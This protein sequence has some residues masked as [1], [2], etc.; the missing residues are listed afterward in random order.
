M[1]LRFRTNLSS[2]EYVQQKAWRY[3]YLEHCPLH[4]NGGCSMARHGTYGRVKP[5]GTRVAR[6]YCPE[7]HCTF[8]LLPDCLA[9]RLSGSLNEI[10]AVVLQVEQA[11][12]INAAAEQLR[13]DIELPGVLRW[14]RR[15]VKG[16]QSALAIINE[17]YSERFA[18]CQLTITAFSQYINGN[19]VLFAL[20]E[21]AALHLAILTPPLGF[22]PQPLVDNRHKHPY[23]Q[24]T[25]P[26][27]PIF[28]Q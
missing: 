11:N 28:F 16:I 17:L 27:P 14:I 6:W 23:Q 2:E 24:R 19:D 10:E 26:D 7:S 9:S 25:G 18:D 13:P 4:P 5:E 3:A 8:S 15:R 20:R 21:I 22:K 12:S 1:Q